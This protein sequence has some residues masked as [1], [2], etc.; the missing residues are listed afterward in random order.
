[1]VAHH[2]VIWS[3]PKG[4]SHEK[5]QES[6]QP[7]GKQATQ[8]TELSDDQMAQVQGGLNPQPLPPGIAALVPSTPIP[9]PEGRFFR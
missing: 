7:L 1:M 2:K 8:M 3:A 6:Q 5:A 4:R 9:P